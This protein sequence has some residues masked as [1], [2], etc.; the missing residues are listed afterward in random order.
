MAIT[1]PQVKD[2]E[3][4]DFRRV[5]P[6]EYYIKTI[7]ED[8]IRVDRWAFSD[9]SC[10]HYWILKPLPAFIDAKPSDFAGFPRDCLCS[11]GGDHWVKG[12]LCGVK[13]APDLSFWVKCN[14]G[15]LYFWTKYCRVEDKRRP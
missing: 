11:I 7:T 3:T 5:E 6:N 8:T 14:A 15:G 10:T 12:T 13:I 2:Y 4:V 9:K 1:I